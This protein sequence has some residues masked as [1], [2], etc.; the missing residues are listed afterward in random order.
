MGP[1]S[2]GHHVHQLGLTDDHLAHTAAL[3]DVLVLL[4]PADGLDAVSAVLADLSTD[5]LRGGYEQRGE[6]RVRVAG[7]LESFN[8]S[9]EDAEGLILRAR[10][11]AGWIDAADLEQPAED[12]EGDYAEE[13]EADA[14]A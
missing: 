3:F 14:Q 7:A 10:V 2:A 13:G 12:G 1:G 5:E 4:P 11:A 8:L 6:Q 9:Q